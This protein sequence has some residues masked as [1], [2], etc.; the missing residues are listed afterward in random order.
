MIN[1]KKCLWEIYGLIST[2]C[3]KV[4]VEFIIIILNVII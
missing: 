3:I 1:I 4:Q 2:L